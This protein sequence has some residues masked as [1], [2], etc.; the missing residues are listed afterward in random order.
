MNSDQA[1]T[2][3]TDYTRLA[4]HFLYAARTAGPTLPF[5]DSLK[6]ADARLLDAGLDT[7]LKR[8]AFWIN[9]YNA[10][11]QVL[12]KKNPD[13]YKTRSAFFTANKIIVAGQAMSLDFIEHGLLRHSKVK[14]SYG[15]LDNPFPSPFEQKFR[16][17]KLDYRIHFALNCGAKSCPPIAFYDPEKLNSQL[18]MA[19]KTYLQGEVTFTKLNNT[20]AVPALM[21]WFSHDFGGDKGILEILKKN[22]IIPAAANP[23]ITYK[24]YDWTLFL[25]NFKAENNG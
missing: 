14:W 5:T 3:I 25:N 24:K 16:V 13:Q 18:D 23:A 8:E 19:V 15:Y 6:K 7:D 9:L 21:N 12:L 20:V 2:P 17:R 4:Q 11:T 22:E 10:Y 1:T